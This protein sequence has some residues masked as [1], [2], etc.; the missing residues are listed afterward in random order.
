[1]GGFVYFLSVSRSVSLN[2]LKLT[3]FRL[4]SNSEKAS[5]FGGLECVGSQ[6]ACVV[7]IGLYIFR[8]QH[9]NS[10]T[11]NMLNEFLQVEPI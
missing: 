10:L 5:A 4:A 2:S 11:L 9:P 8:A 1:M 7:E 6:M 3:C